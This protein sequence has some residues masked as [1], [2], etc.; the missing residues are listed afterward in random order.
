MTTE[1]DTDRDLDEDLGEPDEPEP[2]EDP[3]AHE[4]PTDWTPTEADHA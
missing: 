3:N 4:V 2:P 1:N